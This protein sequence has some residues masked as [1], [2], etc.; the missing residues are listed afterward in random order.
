MEKPT[1]TSTIKTTTTPPSKWK[2]PKNSSKLLPKKS[3]LFLKILKIVIKAT[4]AETT[5]KTTESPVEIEG[6]K[7]KEIFF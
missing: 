7:L 5:Y 1:T 2:N 3:L 6:K 4:I